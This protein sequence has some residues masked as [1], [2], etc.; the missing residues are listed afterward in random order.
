LASLAPV[1]VG[2]VVVKKLRK[3]YAYFNLY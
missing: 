2:Y 3:Y 1:V